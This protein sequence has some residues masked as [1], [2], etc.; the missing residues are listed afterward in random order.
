MSKPQTPKIFYYSGTTIDLVFLYI[1]HVAV[2]AYKKLNGFDERFEM[3]H[4]GPDLCFRAK[5]LGYDVMFVPQLK[6]MH[7][8]IAGRGSI[9]KKKQLAKSTWLWYKKWYLNDKV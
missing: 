4:E 6:S 9:A 7:V 2:S 8:D 3:F 1:K 5:A